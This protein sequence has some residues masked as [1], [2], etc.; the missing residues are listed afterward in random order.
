M[1]P[2]QLTHEKTTQHPTPAHRP[3]AAYLL[4]QPIAVAAVAGCS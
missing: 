4:M 2:S 3:S 1:T